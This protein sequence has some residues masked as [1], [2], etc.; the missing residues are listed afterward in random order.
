MKKLILTG[1][2]AAVGM[3]ALADITVN[4]PKDSDVK[5]L[6]IQCGY[7]SNLGKRKLPERTETIKVNA[8]KAVIPSMPDSAAMYMIPVGER[9]A[10]QVFANAGENITVNVAGMNPQ[11][12]TVSGSP[13]MEAVSAME[14][15]SAKYL[16]AYREE[17]EKQNANSDSMQKYA[18]AYDAVFADYVRNNPASEAAPYALMRMDG[19]AFLEYYGKLAPQIEKS[20]FRPLLEQQKVYV[21]RQVEAECRMAEL[22]S[23]NVDAPAFTFKDMQDK[24]VSLSDFKGKWVILDFWGSWC[25]WCIKGIPE[26]KAAYAKYKPALEVISIDCRDARDT[27]MAAVKKYELPW[28]N[29][30]NPD[31]DGGQILRDYAVQGFPTKVIVDPQGKIRDITVGEDPSF[32]TKLENMMKSTAR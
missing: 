24:D 22:T 21:E 8:G 26:L 25:R 28:V 15:E 4:L 19:E 2:A 6:N 16:K 5:E 32:Y 1:V 11:E 7:V 18:D 12:Y 31:M 3:T 27:W 17:A 20:M 9:Q 30:W 13:L 14:K 23:G 10:I 29:V